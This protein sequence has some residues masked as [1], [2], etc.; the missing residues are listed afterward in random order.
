M[1]TKKQRQ[2]TTAT[3]EAKSWFALTKIVG[4]VRG[5]PV[6]GGVDAA[7]SSIPLVCSLFFF[8]WLCGSSADA[9]N[10][11]GSS[12]AGRESAFGWRER[13]PS[14]TGPAQPW[15]T[16]DPAGASEPGRES[17][18]TSETES[19]QPAKPAASKSGETD[20]SAGS[21]AAS[22]TAAGAS[23]E[24]SGQTAFVGT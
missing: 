15:R 18:A 1:T 17:S 9:S 20:N 8:C 4:R 13:Q 11:P 22:S 2:R 5:F 21:R 14:P 7:Q 10:P 16:A 12:C 24:S 23:A 3:V 6:M 19:G